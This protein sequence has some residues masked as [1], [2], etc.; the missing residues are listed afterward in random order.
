MDKSQF[1]YLATKYPRIVPNITDIPKTTQTISGFAPEGSIYWNINIKKNNI[2]IKQV[3]IKIVKIT[4][5][6]PKKFKN[7]PKEIINTP[8]IQ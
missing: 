1:L 2:V 7:K 6:A 8:K 4:N 3:K 5:F